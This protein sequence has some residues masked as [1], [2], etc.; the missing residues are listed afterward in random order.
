MTI[1]EAQ[2]RQ[3]GKKSLIAEGHWLT[4]SPGA[5][6]EDRHCRGSYTPGRGRGRIAR[7][8]PHALRW[9]SGRGGAS[10]RRGQLERLRRASAEKPS[11]KLHRLSAS[12]MLVRPWLTEKE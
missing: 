6:H 1:G 4:P 8:A 11:E 9:Q 5:W 7:S 3:V 12:P 10:P 2:R